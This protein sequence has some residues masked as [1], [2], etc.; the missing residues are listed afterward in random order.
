MFQILQLPGAFYRK[1]CIAE[2]FKTLAMVGP[3]GREAQTRPTRSAI[4][5]QRP[6]G[7]APES[8]LLISNAQYPA[9]ATLPPIRLGE[10]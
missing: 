2:A 6:Y 1:Q 9:R 4:S 3:W 8:F 10:P 5:N 7:S